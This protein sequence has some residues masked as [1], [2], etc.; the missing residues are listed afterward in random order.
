MENSR[1]MGDID[2]FMYDEELLTTFS[3]EN[4]LGRTFDSLDT[5]WEFY[6]AY[7]YHKGFSVRRSTKRYDKSGATVS[8]EFCCAREGIKSKIAYCDRQRRARADS[9]IGCKAKLMVTFKD[10]GA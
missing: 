10:D 4:V 3:A 6:K 1:A 8:Q 5:A 2:G 9:R 7:G